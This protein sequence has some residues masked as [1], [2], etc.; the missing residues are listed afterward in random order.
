MNFHV[1]ATQFIVLFYLTNGQL[2]D[3]PEP[4]RWLC[5]QQQ[6]CGDCMLTH[7]CCNW[8]YDERDL[9]YRCDF[10]DTLSQCT[11]LEKNKK[12]L[13]KIV[14]KLPFTEIKTA[15][16]AL[17]AIQISPQ[18]FNIVLRKDEPVNLTFTY[19]AAKNYPLELYFLADLS[20]SMK[21]HLDT[22]K[23]LGDSLAH[24]LEQLTKHYKLA[25]GSF[26]DKPGMPYILVDPAQYQNPCRSSREERCDQT[27]LF[28]HSLNFTEEISQFFQQ[29]NSSKISAN[30]DDLDGALEAIYQ[31]LVCDRRFGWSNYARKI[32]LLST[33]SLLHIEGDGI[34]AGVSEVNI[35]ELCLVN[36]T[37]DH[38]QPLKYDFPSVGTIKRLLRRQKTNLIVAV[39][40]DKIKMYDR[41]RKDILLQESFV[42]ELKSN[43]S[44]IL[45]LVKA[46]FNEFI[47]NVEFSVNTSY[48]PELDVKFYADCENTGHF[49]E[50]PGCQNA[51]EEQEINFKAQ[52]TLTKTTPEYSKQV[53]IREKNINEEIE[54]NTEYISGLCQCP[55]DHS[56]KTCINGIINCGLCVCDLGWIGLECN[57]ECQ[58]DRDSCRQH[59]DSMTCSSR[60]DCECGKCICPDPYMGDFC[61]YECP[62]STKNQ[63][64]CS[65]NGICSAGDCLCNKNFSGLDCSCDKGTSNCRL[66]F[67][68]ETL[69][70][71]RGQC[72][73]NNCECSDEYSGTYCEIMR[74][75]QPDS[76]IQNVFCDKY[77]ANVTNYFTANTTDKL[78]AQ[79]A[80]RMLQIEEGS[81]S[82]YAH[83][84][85]QKCSNVYYP[86]KTH[87]CTVKYCYHTGSN[88]VVHLMTYENRCDFMI[89]TQAM[90]IG[91]AVGIFV[92]VVVGGLI[93]IMVKKWDIHKKE[94]AEYKKFAAASAQFN[95]S[96]PLYVSPVSTYEN[97]MRG[98][99]NNSTAGKL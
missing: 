57:E 12:S 95:V 91:L 15:E 23:S 28:K 41:M 74:S 65:G 2:T 70:N 11:N 29:V 80:T 94:K 45:D 8:C 86:N 25:F 54:I 96:N 83:C 44:N 82:D 39:T 77:E 7:S 27:Y 4:L 35:H 61:E 32:I 14:K 16:S 20:Y 66:G 97:P 10:K 33:D 50:T 88:N 90:G 56:N 69:C 59:V 75:N 87:R 18:S 52:F 19:K 43:S 99:R 1:F 36:S 60:G 71:G 55:N 6:N 13:A 53:F 48:S 22:L 34:L 5:R 63:L 79:N 40:K 76:E 73:C 26:L 64:I 46:G 47:R 72:I 17:S 38:T 78:K 68:N 49:I 93:L 67:S 89:T 3:C 84:G 98:K 51:K 58:E 21:E 37:G 42:G 9:T 30:V 85:A 62:V 31:I 24:S 92:A 81:K